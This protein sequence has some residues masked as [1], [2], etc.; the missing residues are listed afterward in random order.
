MKEILLTQ[1]K[2]A[3]VDS[4]Y[5]EELNKFK[6]H[7][8][9]RSNLFYAERNLP[10]INGKQGTVRMHHSVIGVPYKGFIVDHINGC[11]IDNRQKNLR[12]ITQRQNC[13]NRKRGKGRSEYPGVHWNKRTRKWIAGIMIN[14]EGCY[15]GCFT[16]ERDA[17]EV[18]M[19]AVN[20]IGEEVLGYE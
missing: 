18:Y 4:C 9:K 5:F 1:N 15:L 6:W 16:N 8:C 17:F 10:K 3:I 11:G 2:K 13:Q 19:N 20:N 7:T 12:F 14:K